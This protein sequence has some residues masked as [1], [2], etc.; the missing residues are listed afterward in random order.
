MYC[1][2]CLEPI[3]EGPYW[4]GSLYTEADL[5]I[6]TVELCMKCMDTLIEVEEHRCA[7]CFDTIDRVKE[8]W[9]ELVYYREPDADFGDRRLYHESCFSISF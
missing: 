4:E 6:M 2:K 8:E 1:Y 5:P 3:E 9:W 7:E